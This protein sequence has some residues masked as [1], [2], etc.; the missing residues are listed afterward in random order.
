MM[1]TMRSGTALRRTESHEGNCNLSTL[2]SLIN[3]SLIEI[4]GD[5]NVCV[6]VHVCMYTRAQLEPDGCRRERITM[7]VCFPLSRFLS[8]ALRDARARVR[9]QPIPILISHV[10][11]GR[12]NCP[13]WRCKTRPTSQCYFQETLYFARA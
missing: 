8:L 6:C 10:N 11:R 1:Q 2:T 12:T 4:E 5:V 3:G 9:S 13:T 7:H